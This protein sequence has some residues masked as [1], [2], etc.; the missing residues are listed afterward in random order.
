VRVLTRALVFQHA[1]EPPLAHDERSIDLPGRQRDDKSW[2]NRNRV[3]LQLLPPSILGIQRKKGPEHGTLQHP[4]VK[5][6]LPPA[7]VLPRD[8]PCNR[9]SQVAEQLIYSLTDPS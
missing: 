6:P 4:I 2:L 3:L 7:T 8:A 1:D 5:L 9:E